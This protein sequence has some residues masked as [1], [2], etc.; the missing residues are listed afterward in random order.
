M[1]G[2]ALAYALAVTPSYRH[3]WPSVVT[4]TSPEKGISAASDRCPVTVEIFSGQERSGVLVSVLPKELNCSEV[5]FILQLRGVSHICEPTARLK[6]AR[7]GALA[8][9]SCECVSPSHWAGTM[10]H[11]ASAVV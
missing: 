10:V 4:F 11:D 7:Q 6:V 9:C 1:W 2:Q 8:S 3:L 5:R